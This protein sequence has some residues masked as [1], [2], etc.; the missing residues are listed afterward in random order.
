MVTPPQWESSLLRGLPLLGSTQPGGRPRSAS[1]THNQLRLS[2]VR[3]P[4]KSMITLGIFPPFLCRRTDGEAGD[5]EATGCPALGGLEA[6]GRGSREAV[7]PGGRPW[8]AVQSSASSLAPEHHPPAV[9]LS[10]DCGKFSLWGPDFTWVSGALWPRGPRSVLSP[11]LEAV[12]HTDA[13]GAS[14]VHVPACGLTWLTGL[15]GPGPLSSKRQEP[16]LDWP[17]PRGERSLLIGCRNI[18]WSLWV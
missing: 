4:V 18:P 14:S 6:L 5:Q 15:C 1:M 16:D 8:D 2:L 12:L 3:P 17:H 9:Q 13:P 10:P 11:P 7:E